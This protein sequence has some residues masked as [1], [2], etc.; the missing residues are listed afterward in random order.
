MLQIYKHQKHSKCQCFM[1][2]NEDTVHILQC[3]HHDA[4]NLWNQSIAQLEQ[5]MINNQ[6]HPKLIELIVLGL[7]SWHS[8][9]VLPLEY[10]I[11]EPFLQIAYRKQRCIGWRSFIEGFWTTE[12]RICQTEYPSQYNSQKSCILW[13]SRVQRKIWHIAWSM[14]DQPN[15]YLHHKGETIH[16][17]EMRALDSEINTEW[18]TGIDQLP[19][20]YN[21]LFQG[22]KQ[23]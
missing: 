9:L 20:S 19:L 12:W 5:W 10:D 1:M 23:Q 3:P 14:W 15:E 4:T 2:D 22:L 21:Y 8:S 17:F 11:L 18:D 16:A 7:Q 6:G 13:I